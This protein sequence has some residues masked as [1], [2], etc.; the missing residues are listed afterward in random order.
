MV[1]YSIVL[2]DDHK[3]LREGLKSLIEKESGFQVAAQAANGEELLALLEKQRC[4]IIV[5]DLSMPQMDGMATLIEIKKR[6]PKIKTLILTM[7]KDLAHF[8]QAMASGADGYILKEDAYDQLILA[9]K[10]ILKAKSF[11]SPALKNLITD[12]FIRSADEREGSSLN[13]LT[14]RELQILKLIAQGLP[15]KG[16]AARLKLSIRTVET[17]RSN[18]SQ[19]LDIHNTAGLVKY[20]IAKGLA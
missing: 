2:A 12:Q 20:A 19:K 10:T 3:I 17:H 15:N 16:I 5:L 11:I 14:K 4:D 13:I 6:F 9:L 18:L 1:N 8:K 7:Q